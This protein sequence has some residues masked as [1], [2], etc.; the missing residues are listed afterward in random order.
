MAF[1][2]WLLSLSSVFKD[3]SCFHARQPFIP[4]YRGVIFHCVFSFIMWGTFGLPHLLAILNNAAR[5]SPVRIFVWTCLQF[6]WTCVYLR[7]GVTGPSEDCLPSILNCWTLFQRDGT[8]FALP[9]SVCWGVD[10]ICLS[11]VIVIIWVDVKWHFT[12]VV[13]CTYLLTSD[14]EPLLI[15]LSAIYIL[16]CRSVCSHPSSIFKLGYL[17]FYCCIV[18]ILHIFWI[19]DSC[20]INGL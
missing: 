15:L 14:V 5:N 3:Q 10:N 16:L 17:S 8:N 18:I 6:P 11:F 2:D 20:Q 1:W 19:P 4:F 12:M 7:N 9:L 13:I